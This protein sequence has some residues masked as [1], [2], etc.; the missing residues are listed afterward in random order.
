MARKVTVDDRRSLVPEVRKML[1]T[2]KKPHDHWL[3]KD[4]SYVEHFLHLLCRR[5]G[6]DYLH[7]P[8]DHYKAAEE[9]SA[10]LIER[11]RI[12]KMIEILKGKAGE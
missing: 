5:T 2:G 9:I 10:P 4:K 1:E 8:E 6:A 12:E 7:P 3:H 11:D